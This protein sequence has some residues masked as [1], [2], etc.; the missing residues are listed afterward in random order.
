MK[1]NKPNRLTLSI[2]LSLFWLFFIPASHSSDSDYIKTAILFVAYDQ[3]ESNAFLRIQ[4]RLKE[5]NIPYRILAMGRAAEVF[6]NDPALIRVAELTRNN[7][8][9]NNRNQPLNQRLVYQLTEMI[10]TKIVY[11][12]M[13]SRA[14]AQIANAWERT[15]SRIIA[16]YDNFE[17][18]DTVQYVQPFL[19]EL[20][21]ADA[22]H[23]PSARTASS[24]QGLTKALGAQVIVT[25][26]PT[27]EDWDKS[28]QETDRM[29][30]RS[31]LGIDSQRPVALFIG[32]YSNSYSEALQTFISAAAM[33]PD[34][35]FL[36]TH[37]PKTDGRLER[38][39]ITTSLAKNIH[40]LDY[41]TFSPA[42][43]STIASIVIVHKSSVAQ[44]AI[45]QGK[46]V[47]YV[48]RPDYHNLMLTE[49]L[50]VRASTPKPLALIIDAHLRG[51]KTPA[52]ADKLGI[53]D[54]P[55]RNIAQLMAEGLNQYDSD[56]W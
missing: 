32:D 38:S 47:I 37:H 52:L 44:Q 18:I 10:S 16:F 54:S 20:R 4:D 48:A 9:Y 36:V 53:P 1:N 50:A 30:L 55:S 23:V 14:Q 35:L 25:G 26:Q 8:L 2:A 24:F 6:E 15:G 45:Y 42:T 19:A 29:L 40:L 39:M 7:I 5:A 51:Y 27:I 43:L 49:Q 28:Y 21:Y 11:T 13:A 33:L 12:G 3:G 17:P 34:I 31:T 56:S 41:G 22:F 46:Q